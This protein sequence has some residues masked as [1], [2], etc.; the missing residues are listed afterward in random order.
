MIWKGNRNAL[1]SLSVR[2][3]NGETRRRRIPWVS[4]K[5]SQ[6]VRETADFGYDSNLATRDG[7]A[8]IGWNRSHGNIE[9]VWILNAEREKGRGRRGDCTNWNF[10]EKFERS[11]S[12]RRAERVDLDFIFFLYFFPY[13]PFFPFLNILLRFYPLVGDSAVYTE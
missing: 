1:R 8:A 13:L 10:R 9:G 3:V 2:L 7:L 6:G 11:P 4:W 12:R 5:L